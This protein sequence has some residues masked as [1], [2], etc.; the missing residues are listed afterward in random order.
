M[1]DSGIIIRIAVE[2]IGIYLRNT[3][4]VKLIHVGDAERVAKVAI[5]DKAEEEQN[6]DNEESSDGNVAAI[7]GNSAVDNAEAPEV[8]Q[9][10]E[11]SED[12]E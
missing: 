9:S 10:Q 12:K 8:S 2:N 7:E 5:V 1:T 4:G 6:S 3:Q 11:Q